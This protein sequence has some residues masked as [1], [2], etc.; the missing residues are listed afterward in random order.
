MTKLDVLAFGAH[1]DDVELSAAGT[2]LKLASEGKKTGIVDLT[3]GELGTRGTAEIRDQ[4]AADSAQILGL[5][6]RANLALPDGFFQHNEESIHK[7]IAAVRR[8]RPEVVLAPAMADRHPDHGRGSKLVRDACFLAGLK[9]IETTDSEGNQQSPWRPKRVFFFI[10]DYN[11]QPDFVVDITGFWE[12]K[13]EAILAFSSQFYNPDF[14][15]EETYISNADFLHFQEARMR[16]MGHIIGARYGEGFQ[17]E[18]ALSIHSP[19]DL[20]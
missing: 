12:K 7:V 11:L 2:L 19:L 13:K 8:L 20:I 3:R 5:A 10:Q 4:E 9:K 1:P 6:A 16:N 15:G 14:D 17:S 18:T